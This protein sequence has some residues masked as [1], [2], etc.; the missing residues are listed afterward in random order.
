MESTNNKNS[1]DKLGKYAD[2]QAMVQKE[3]ETQFERLY[4]QYASKFGVASVPLH[5]HNGADSPILGDAS[6]SNFTPLPSVDNGVLSRT[7]LGAQTVNTPSVGPTGNQNPQQPNVYVMTVP[8]IY[9][10]S[11]VGPGSAFNAGDAPYGTVLMFANGSTLSNLWINTIDGWYG[12]DVTI[13]PL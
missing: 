9:G 4:K 8:V 10:S 3:I 7:Q 6:I 12:I 5:R 2:I 1:G 13:G 11:G